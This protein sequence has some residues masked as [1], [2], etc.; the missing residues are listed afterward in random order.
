M[1]MISMFTWDPL[2]YQDSVNL[3]LVK[4]NRTLNK[5]MRLWNTKTPGRNKDQNCYFY[6]YKV[7]HSVVIW[8]GF[9]WVS[10]HV[11]SIS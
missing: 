7:I 9:S 10:E 8:K 4:H 6:D 5:N 2:H 1:L 3:Q 11:V